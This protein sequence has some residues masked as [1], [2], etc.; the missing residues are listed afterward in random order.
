[1]PEAKVFFGRW[2]MTLTLSELDANDAYSGLREIAVSEVPADL[3]DNDLQV[4]IVP[5]YK[6]Q[7]DY[8]YFFLRAGQT[9]DLEHILGM[10][11]AADKFQPHG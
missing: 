5:P 4:D 11:H 8:Q 7:N 2:L 9:H 10:V 3:K 6:P 1:M